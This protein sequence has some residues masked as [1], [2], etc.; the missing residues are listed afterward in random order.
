MLSQ[1]S[2]TSKPESITVLS[3]ENEANT[4]H[5]TANNSSNNSVLT[6]MKSELAL[7]RQNKLRKTK[8]LVLKCC[9]RNFK[10]SSRFVG[11]SAVLADNPDNVTLTD[12]EALHVE[13]LAKLG[14]A[15][16]SSS[17]SESSDNSQ[18]GQLRKPKQRRRSRSRHLVDPHS[19]GMYEPKNP[20][21][22]SMAMK[23]PFV[24]N[25]YAHKI[26]PHYHVEA[27]GTPHVMGIMPHTVYQHH[28]TVNSPPPHGGFARYA[29]SEFPT[30]NYSFGS[31]SNYGGMVQSSSSQR[32]FESVQHVPQHTASPNLS[33]PP[34][35]PGTSGKQPDAETI[36]TSTPVEDAENNSKP[37]FSSS[38]SEVTSY[39]IYNYAATK[40]LSIYTFNNF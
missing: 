38:S 13:C 25:P 2:H 20:Y 30:G 16:V 14:D 7:L 29:S 11:I 5:T 27:L 39:V 40:L 24:G 36:L 21:T 28:P 3:D 6:P 31:H 37:L 1:A 4:S 34:S 18:P 15:D 9:E 12:M 22:L 23:H 17:S 33:S 10:F 35:T 26:E 19:V 8:R 32:Q